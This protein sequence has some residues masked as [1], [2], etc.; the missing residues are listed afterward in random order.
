MSGRFRPS[1]RSC[2]RPA[3]RT[4][5]DMCATTATRGFGRSSSARGS[6]RQCCAGVF[7]RASCGSSW[8]LASD[9]QCPV[10]IVCAQLQ[11]RI[12][13]FAERRRR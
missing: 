11:H 6:T 7:D 12:D 5:G 10:S 8:G 4:T 9:G 1:V 3:M 13:D 2:A